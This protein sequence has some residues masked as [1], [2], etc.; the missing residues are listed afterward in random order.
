[1]TQDA[2]TPPPDRNAAARRERR[3]I[4]G[5]LAIVAAATLLLVAGERAWPGEADRA[6]VWVA[7]AVVLAM[8]AFVAVVA[9]FFRETARALAPNFIGFVGAVGIGFFVAG[10][11]PPVWRA[12]L[13]LAMTVLAGAALWAVWYGRM[14]SGG[15]P[16]R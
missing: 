6:L 16:R 4:G 12:V 13:A 7:T 14:G 8:A 15:G 1:M 10:E 5:L 11:L 9:L 2:E 3:L